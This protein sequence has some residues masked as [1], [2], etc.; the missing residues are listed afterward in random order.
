MK[1][2]A[3]SFLTEAQHKYVKHYCETLESALDAPDGEYTIEMDRVRAELGEKPSFYYSEERQQ[4]HRDCAFCRTSDDIL[5]RFGY[6]SGCGIRS[7]LVQ[8][9][10]EIETVRKK[11]NNS[12][13]ANDPVRDAVSMFDSF[14]GRYMKQLVRRTSL[15]PRRSSRLQAM[16]FHALKRAADEFKNVF[17]IGILEGLSGD[18]VDFAIRM[19]HRRHVYE[20]KA[21]IV[22]EKYLQDSEDTEVRLG[23]EIRETKETAHR[24]ADVLLKMARNLHEGFHSLYPANDHPRLHRS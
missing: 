16:R 23:Q 12:N 19:F 22:D 3:H 8:F 7:D 18:D 1:G 15:S 20:H 10:S 17:D 2:E 4:T 11:I 5:G 6:C 9:E 24:L 13:S 14:A 21:G